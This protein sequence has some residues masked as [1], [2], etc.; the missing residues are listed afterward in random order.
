MPHLVMP[1]KLALVGG[2]FWEL[3]QASIHAALPV[4]HPCLTW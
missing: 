3:R 2:F 4:R 1:L